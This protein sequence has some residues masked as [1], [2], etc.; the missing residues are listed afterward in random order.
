M[1]TD[2]EPYIAIMMEGNRVG[3][4]PDGRVWSTKISKLLGVLAR[5]EREKIHTDARKTD[6]ALIDL[7]HPSEFVVELRPTT[8]QQGY[9]PL[10]VFKWAMQQLENIGTDKPVDPEVDARTASLI[11]ELAKPEPQAYQKFWVN[12]YA[13]PVH[14]DEVYE[15]KA[16]ALAAKRV[17][18]ERPFE[19]FEGTSM[20][21]LVGKLL[22]V[23]GTAGHQTFA[24]T[25]EVGPER[26]ECQFTDDM[27]D[28]LR[29]NLFRKVRIHGRIHYHRDSP[30]P[31]T[32]DVRRV[33]P[34]NTGEKPHYR[35]MAG[36]LK[37]YDRPD[38]KLFGILH[39]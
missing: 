37:D 7:K 23:D 11:A 29:N 24:I 30:H 17:L 33:E 32:I 9:D 13:D 35:S 21:T 36:L 39:E 28:I 27:K 1:A 20:G 22:F 16:R 31:S 14:F 6:Y 5:M 10:P 18:I 8:K 34:I 38:S 12:G 15:A 3:G 26:V 25:P 4:G 19:W 2:K